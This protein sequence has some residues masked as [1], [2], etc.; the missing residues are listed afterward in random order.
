MVKQIVKAPG[1]LVLT[2]FFKILYLHRLTYQETR[3]K[4]W[5]I[6]NPFR[7]RCPNT[8]FANTSRRDVSRC[9]EGQAACVSQSCGETAGHEDLG[10]DWL[11]GNV[12]HALC[13]L[14]N[15]TRHR[16]PCYWSTGFALHA[17]ASELRIRLHHDVWTA[18][19]WEKPGGRSYAWRW[20]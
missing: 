7:C 16:Q 4:W 1:P 17:D 14:L 5:S 9:E 8:Y 11:T 13:K 2:L 15:W 18:G 12:H 10:R 6:L 19:W 3:L 20:W